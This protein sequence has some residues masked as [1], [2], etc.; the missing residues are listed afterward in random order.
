ML[1]SDIQEQEFYQHL[2]LKSLKHKNHFTT[3]FNDL[4]LSSNKFVNLISRH[5]YF[6][7]IN[8]SHDTL[9]LLFFL[10]L[11]TIFIIYLCF[12]PQFAHSLNSSLKVFR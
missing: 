11:G 2:L 9:L 4:K 7:N 8:A 10:L 12:Y 5:A 3:L 1:I 6:L